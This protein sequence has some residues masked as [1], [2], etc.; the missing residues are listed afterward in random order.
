M[1]F[2]FMENKLS[3]ELLS[4]Q[5]RRDMLYPLVVDLTKKGLRFHDELAELS[6]LFPD[7]MEELWDLNPKLV[8]YPLYERCGKILND[9]VFSVTLPTDLVVPVFL[10]KKICDEN[11][12]Y[13]M[14]EARTNLFL[15]LNSQGVEDG[16]LLDVK[17]LIGDHSSEVLYFVND[18]SNK[19]VELGGKVDHCL[20]N[21]VVEG[22]TEKIK[23]GLVEIQNKIGIGSS[24]IGRPKKITLAP[25]RENK[26]FGHKF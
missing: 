6:R 5:I 8:K 17:K 21:G 19:I 7:N 13:Y 16:N 23:A 1:I 10:I 3:Y 25:R 18:V 11:D 14:K 20:R 22:E 12:I 26:T 15:F 4:L 9:L 24:T 2:Y